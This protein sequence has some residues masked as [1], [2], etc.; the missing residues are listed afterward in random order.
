LGV[1]VGARGHGTSIP[2]PLSPIFLFFSA[3]D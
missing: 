2:Y 1:G 3:V